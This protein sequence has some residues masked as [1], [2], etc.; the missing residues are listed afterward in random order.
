MSGRRGPIALATL[1]ACGFFGEPSDAAA[2]TPP[3]VQMDLL[4][5]QADRLSEVGDHAGALTKLVSV[6]VRATGH[7]AGDSC[8]VYE[9]V[10]WKDR[11]G[12]GWHNPG[13]E[14]SD[15]DPVVC[16]NWEDA[17]SFV[18]WLSEVTGH[19][20][21]FP[22]ESQWEYAARAGTD[23]KFHFGDDESQL[24]Q[25]GNCAVWSTRLDKSPASPMQFNS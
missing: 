6:F 11:N 13:F 22:T 16:V 2:Q 9:G 1:L 7:S 3:A 4:L 23:T 5:M 10:E 21:R 19:N 25:R 17:Q 12:R 15:A 8:G 14:Q 20:Y 18:A 24:C